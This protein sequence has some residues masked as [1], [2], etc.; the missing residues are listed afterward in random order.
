MGFR[1]VTLKNVETGQQ[2]TDVEVL[3]QDSPITEAQSLEL[4]AR[5]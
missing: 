2:N 4:L 1:T 3:V 5:L